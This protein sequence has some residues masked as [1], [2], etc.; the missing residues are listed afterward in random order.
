[1]APLP[2]YFLPR[3]P[4]Y[5]APARLTAFTRLY[6]GAVLLA[7]GQSVDYPL[8]AP[9]WQFL[10]WLCDTQDILLHG[11]GNPAIRTFEPRQ[12]NDVEE[13]GNR[14]AV[15]AA[16][17]GIWP[18]FFAIVDRER[19][20][21]S[22]VNGCFRLVGADGAV[23]DPYYYFSI[24]ADAAPHQPWRVGTIYILPRAG[25][26]QQ[27]RAWMRGVQ[28]EFAQWASLTPVEP[29]ARLAVT[30]ADFPFLDRIRRHDMDVVSQRAERDPHGFPWLADV[31]DDRTP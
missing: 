1:M 8:A 9:T 12:A 10:C 18:L 4:L 28:V 11:S 26:A 6:T 30:P 3:P 16:S 23:S 22:L 27:P 21:R 5:L 31:G 25:F 14:R 29:L 7:H 19:H 15:Y 24:N 2:P 20:V 13:F 17:D